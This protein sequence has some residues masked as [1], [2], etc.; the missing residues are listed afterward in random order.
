MI[1]NDLRGALFLLDNELSEIDFS[2]MG[3]ERSLLKSCFFC[4]FH[5]IILIS[6]IYF[7]DLYLNRNG[8]FNVYDSVFNV[9]C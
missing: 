2:F 8:E 9:S 5:T 1:Y 4:L 3:V 7:V 6:I